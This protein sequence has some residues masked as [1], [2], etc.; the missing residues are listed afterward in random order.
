MGEDVRDVI[1]IGGGPGGLTAAIYT[2]RAGLDTLVLEKAVCGGLAATTDLL[3]NY[4]GFPEGI[5]GM[6]L[7][8]KFKSQAQKF[9]TQIQEFKEVKNIERDGYVIS[10]GTDKEEYRAYG[11]IIASGSIPKK[12]N[13]PGEDKFTGKGVSYCATC[14]G[15]LYKGKEVVVVG[16]GNSGLQETE[17]LLKHAKSVTIVEFLPHM[18]GEKI[19]QD[20]LKKEGNA[21]FLLNHILTSINGKDV[22]ESVT[23][24]NRDTNEEKT[25]ETS[26]VFIYAGFLP[27]SEFAKNLVET[28]KD[29]YIITSKNM[30]ASVRG[31]YAV[32]D[33]RSK[34]FRQVAIACGEGAIAGIAVAEYVNKLR[35]TNY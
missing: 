29:G 14:D 22:V 1:I 18:T 3:E 35:I 33:I 15:P 7:M 6:D 16:A 12:L 17:Y 10:V 28:D 27:Y 11:V 32:G 9:G 26:G 8:N 34:K 30:Q 21:K 24:R 19:L 5:N 13:V 2:A 23:V 20:R 31:I 4:P 25:F